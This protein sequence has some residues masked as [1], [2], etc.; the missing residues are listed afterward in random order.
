MQSRDLLEC[1]HDQDK[2]IE[3]ERGD[4]CDHV[5]STPCSRQALAVQRDHRDGKRHQRDCTYDARA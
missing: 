1:L 3:I 4:G 2:N 5:G